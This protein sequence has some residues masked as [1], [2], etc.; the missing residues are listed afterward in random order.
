MRVESKM[1]IVTATSAEQFEQARRLVKEYADS[2]N[3]DLCFQNFDEEL[4]NLETIYSP[5]GGSLLLAFYDKQIAGCVAVRK[6]E[7]DAC[8]MKRLFVKSVF[9][10]FGIGK[11]LVIAVI[12]KARQLGYERMR[13]DTLPSMAKAQKLYSSFGFKKIP[14]Y[15]YNPDPQTVFME[16][17]LTK[18]AGRKLKI[19][20]PNGLKAGDHLK[21][22]GRS[23][24]EFENN[25]IKSLKDFS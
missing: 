25:L 9:Q 18:N 4:I 23:G 7:A 17:N 6:L 22:E 20:L 3:V 5:P 15:R 11:N 21:L 8:E 1:E 10:G 12:E 16:L 19:D 14:A 24:F 13:L 2:L